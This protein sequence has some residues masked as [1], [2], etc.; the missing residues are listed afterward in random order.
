MAVGIYTL[1]GLLYHLWG[2]IV[3]TSCS[4]ISHTTSEP[5]VT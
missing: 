1:G 5:V 3:T 4:Y 2:G